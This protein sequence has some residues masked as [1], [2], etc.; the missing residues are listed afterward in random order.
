LESGA[1]PLKIIDSR[2]EKRFG[3]LTLNL[4]FVALDLDSDALDL[5]FVAADLDSRSLGPRKRFRP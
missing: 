4:V 3:F 5:G 2:K 1:K